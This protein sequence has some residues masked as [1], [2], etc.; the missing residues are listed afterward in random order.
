MD[1]AVSD[2]LGY[3]LI[4]SLIT[5]SVGVVYVAG[6]GSLD[7]LRNAERFNNAERAFDVLDSNLE[8][9]GDDKMAPLMK[10]NR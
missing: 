1:R 5:S 2:V 3:V 10:N 6:Y 4:F 8:E 7:S 9:F